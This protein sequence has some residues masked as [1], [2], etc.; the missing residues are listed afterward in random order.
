MAWEIRSNG[1]RY[2][3]RSFRDT[4]GRVRKQY[5]GT[6]EKAQAALESLQREKETKRKLK[7]ELKRLYA[8][9]QELEEHFKVFDYLMK[10]RVEEAFLEAGYHNTKSRG[11]RRRR[12]NR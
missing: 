4:D 12:V 10:Q 8:E 3:Y 1:K 7:A 5:L 2:L 6:G 9:Q 11:L